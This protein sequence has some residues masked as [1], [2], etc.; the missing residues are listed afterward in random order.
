MDVPL[1]WSRDVAS[2]LS[3]WASTPRSPSASPLSPSPGFLSE[4]LIRAGWTINPA[5]KTVQVGLQLF[6]ATIFTDIIPSSHIGSV[7]GL[8]NAIGAI[9]GI[10]SPIATGVIVKV[11]GSFQLVLMIGGCSILIA[12]VFLLFVVPSLNEPWYEFEET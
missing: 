6:S 4:R 7:S 9:T 12:S 1:I 2:R 3:R 11:T 5:H 8:V 10:V